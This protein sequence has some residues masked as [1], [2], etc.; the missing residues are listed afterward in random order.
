MHW[1]RLSSVTG[2]HSPDGLHEFVP[3]YQ[4]V[5]V[6]DE[7]A[8]RHEGLQPQVDRA[9]AWEAQRSLPRVGDDAVDQERGWGR[10]TD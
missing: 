4:P 1:T 7:M 8:A 10:I 2:G 9:S 3:R 6:L 5:R